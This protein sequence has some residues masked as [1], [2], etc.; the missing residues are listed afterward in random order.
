MADSI[1]GNVRPIWCTIIETDELE[2][3][4]TTYYLKE[5]DIERL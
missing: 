1:D 2:D 4:N 3:I 5:V